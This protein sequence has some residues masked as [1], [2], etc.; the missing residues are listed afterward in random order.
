V[1]HNRW[2]KVRLTSHEVFLGRERVEIEY[3]SMKC[4]Y[5][6]VGVKYFTTYLGIS[7]FASR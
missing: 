1:K 4:T 3:V 6:P 7:L 2:G 5:F